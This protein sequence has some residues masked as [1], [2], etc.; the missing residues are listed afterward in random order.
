MN[1]TLYELLD[2]IDGDYKEL[3][4]SFAV[5]D[6]QSA[7]WTLRKILRAQ[8]NI[9]ERRAA[10]DAVRARVAKWEEEANGPDFATIAFMQ[11]KLEPYIADSLQGEKRRSVKLPSGTAGFRASPDRVEVEDE[12][13]ALAWCEANLPAA[14]KTK[15][16]LSLTEIKAS[17]KAGGAM[18]EAVRL[19][20]GETRFY[21]KETDEQ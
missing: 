16:Y 3:T 12:A 21:V 13:A 10:A 19:V 9:E 18:P 20:G 7:D 17:L 2:E 1:E 4:P 5:K 15:K 14:V 11:S 8:H 6:L